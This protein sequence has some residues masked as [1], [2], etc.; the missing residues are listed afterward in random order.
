VHANIHAKPE[1]VALTLHVR[2][3]VARSVT[4][5]HD[6]RSTAP[7]DTTLPCKACLKDNRAIPAVRQTTASHHRMEHL[8][9]AVLTHRFVQLRVVNALT[10]RKACSQQACF[11]LK[12]VAL[13]IALDGVYPLLPQVSSRAEGC[14]H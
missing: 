9:R 14:I 4:S 1:N 5:H 10:V 7:V 2:G 13:G 11:Q 3:Q 12:D 6:G 8:K